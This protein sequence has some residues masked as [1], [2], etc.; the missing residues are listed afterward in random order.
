V[1]LT[2]RWSFADL[3]RLALAAVL[4]VAG[5]I[6]LVLVPDH[7]A[8]ST[9]M[10]LGFVGATIA[11]LGLAALVLAWPHRLVY[12]G[13]IV[14]AVGLIGLYAYNVMIGLPF[15]A[16]HTE[17]ADQPAASAE[18]EGEHTEGQHAEDGE[19]AAHHTEGLVLGAGEPVDAV[20]AT[21]KTL[22]A[23]SVGLALVLLRRR[24]CTA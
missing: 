17:V 6:H 14:V 15:A 2:R 20:G 13:T 12:L 11:E 3:P 19:H 4:A 23:V 10:G 21:T 16:G 18:H 22:E 9:L 7:F 1:T 5:L 8:E 24:R